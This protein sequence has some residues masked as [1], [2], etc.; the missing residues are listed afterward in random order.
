MEW[1]G[2]ACVCKPGC[3]P[4]HGGNSCNPPQCRSN[5]EY[6]PDLKRCVCKP[7]YERTLW[8]FCV[9]SHPECPKKNEYW[10]G[11]KCVCKPGEL[12]SLPYLFSFVS[13]W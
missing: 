2:H 7:G 13:C 9:P 6:K 1:N 4:N 8:G 5:E 11:E 3:S 10:D 12:L